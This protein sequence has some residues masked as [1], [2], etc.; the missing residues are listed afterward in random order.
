MEMITK[1]R[2]KYREKG[3]GGET[4]MLFSAFFKIN[5]YP[6]MAPVVIVLVGS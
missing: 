1:C 3:G 4:A 5:Y 2:N 6:C